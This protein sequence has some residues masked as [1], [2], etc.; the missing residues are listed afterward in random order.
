MT[1][2]VTDGG[3]RSKSVEFTVNI[4]QD[5]SP[6]V[7]TQVPEPGFKILENLTDDTIIARIKVVVTVL[8]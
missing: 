5:A 3:N 2:T 7:F 6:P 8:L 4:R 1:I